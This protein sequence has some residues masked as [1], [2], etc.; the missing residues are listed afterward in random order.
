[1]VSSPESYTT[2]V[3]LLSMSTVIIHLCLLVLNLSFLTHLLHVITHPFQHSFYYYYYYL[4]ILIS[5]SS[6]MFKFAPPV[7]QVDDITF[8]QHVPLQSVATLR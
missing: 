1:M 3:K 4:K 2:A 7:K 8:Y 5:M 6:D